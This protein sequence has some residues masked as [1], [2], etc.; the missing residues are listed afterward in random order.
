MSRGKRNSPL[1]NNAVRVSNPGAI[2]KLDGL[3]S[4]KSSI[5]PLQ[6]SIKQLAIDCKFEEGDDLSVYYHAKTKICFATA[7][8]W[9]EADIDIDNFVKKIRALPEV[10]AAELEAEADPSTIAAMIIAKVPTA[11]IHEYIND[12]WTKERG[13]EI[14]KYIDKYDSDLMETE[15]DE[16]SHNDWDLPKYGW[17]QII[18]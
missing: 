15:L 11:L 9:C 7:G 16:L 2:G 18:A 14:N 1:S 4:S 10:E 5:K 13:E 3:I 17:K 8:D 12:G 6:D